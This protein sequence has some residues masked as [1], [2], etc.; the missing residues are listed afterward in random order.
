VRSI[1]GGYALSVELADKKLTALL[2]TDGKTT[3]EADNL[4]TTSAI[5]LELEHASRQPPK[6]LEVRQGDLH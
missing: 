4:T 3:L 2:P 5:K 1:D 6:I